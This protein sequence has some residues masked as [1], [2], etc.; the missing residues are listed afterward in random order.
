MAA[1]SPCRPSSH[2]V[3]SRRSSHK[4]SLACVLTAF[5]ATLV[6]PASVH[7]ALTASVADVNLPA[8]TSSHVAQTTMGTMILTATDSEPGAGWNVTI[9]S[10]AFAYTGPHGGTSIPAAN[11]SIT[12]AQSPILV[13]G[14]AIDPSG[15]PKVPPSGATGTLDI[16]RKTIQADIGFGGGTYTQELAVSL[17]VPA[18]SRAGTYTAILTVTASAGP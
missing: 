17:V 7:A 18:D 13:T 2:L 14:Q 8:V 1:S 4:S 11:L 15:G 3:R 5:V 10:S 9:L 12:D 16:A 6:A